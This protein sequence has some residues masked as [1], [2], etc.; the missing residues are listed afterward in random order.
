MVFAH[1]F[2]FA[3][4]RCLR[5]VY[6]YF[7]EGI[8]IKVVDHEFWTART[9]QFR[10]KKL[11]VIITIAA[12]STQHLQ[13]SPRYVRNIRLK[14]DLEICHMILLENHRP[15]PKLLQI[16]WCQMCL[17]RRFGILVWESSWI[18]GICIIFNVDIDIEFLRAQTEKIF[19]ERRFRLREKRIC[20]LVVNS[21]I[22]GL[23]TL[24]VWGPFYTSTDLG[25][26]SAKVV[27]FARS[28]RR[29]WNRADFGKIHRNQG[30][31]RFMWHLTSVI[32]QNLIRL[33]SL[34]SFRGPKIQQ[35]S[36]KIA[37]KLPYGPEE[38]GK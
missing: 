26:I 14:N 3:F 23:G 13:A 10:S 33:N 1:D 18:L 25:W 8:S 37:K 2:S 34:T 19:Q 16:R 9:G 36:Q 7:D 28:T 38:D 32:C 12:A 4:Q 21:T 30:E 24:M 15:I 11:I 29:D 31:F 20:R 6:K 35:I 22:M 17:K 5:S 27:F